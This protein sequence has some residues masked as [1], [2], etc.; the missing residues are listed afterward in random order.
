MRFAHLCRI[1]P[2]LF[3]NLVEMYFESIARLWRAVAAFGPARWFVGK[4]AQPFE[5]VAGHF[6]SH[7]LQ[8]A[9]IER[10]RHAVAAIGAAVE[11]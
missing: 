11:K 6:V 3:S 7:R 2:Q 1:Q 4:D 10:A 8:R 9:G 5:F